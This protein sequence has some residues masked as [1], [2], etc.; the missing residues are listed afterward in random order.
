MNFIAHVWAREIIDSRGNP[1]VEVEVIT[2]NGCKGRAAVPAGASTGRFEVCELRDK[3]QRRYLGRGVLQAVKNVRELIAPR[4]LDRHVH[5]QG[6]IDRL[7][8]DLDGTVD[9]SQLGANAILAVSLA[10]ARAAAHSYRL[11]LYRYLGGLSANRLPVPMVN[12]INGGVHADSGLSVQEFMVVPHGA[13]TFAR[14]VQ[15]SAEVFHQL[16]RLLQK[17]GHSTA[18]G[19]EGGYAPCLDNEQQAIE[20]ILRAIGEAGYEA[21]KDLSLALDVAASEFYRQGCYHLGDKQLTS[22]E[23]VDYLVD[24]QN[25]YPLVSIEDGLAEE[26]WDGFASLTTRLGTKCKIVGDDLFVTN[27]DRLRIG[28][29]KGAGNTILIKLNQIGT[30]TETLATIAVAN[31]L[32]Y[33]SI[34]SHRSGETEDTTIADL[35]VATNVGM[36]KTGSMSRS[37]RLSKYNQLL[38]IEEE[39]ADDARFSYRG[40]LPPVPSS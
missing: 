38:R 22:A 4:L 27:G 32:G 26:D 25:N 12:V 7:L 8:I 31:D 2:D 33:Q 11:P 40:A 28:A 18:V 16:K 37:D 19:D 1:T 39:L 34:I 36:I 5:A 3:D 20:F 6:E 9:K 17:D 14:A 21:G 13:E 35:A 15:M 23:M 10:C 30:L 24:L 29:G